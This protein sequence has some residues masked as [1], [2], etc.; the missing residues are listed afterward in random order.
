MTSPSNE[1]WR[2]TERCTA[3]P[4]SRPYPDTFHRC[5]E[6][7][8]F[9]EYWVVRQGSKEMSFE[10]HSRVEDACCRGQ[11]PRAHAI[12]PHRTGFHTADLPALQAFRG[13]TLQRLFGVSLADATG[14]TSRLRFACHAVISCADRRIATVA[15]IAMRNGFLTSRPLFRRVSSPIRGKAIADVQRNIIPPL[16]ASS[17]SLVTARPKTVRRL[18]WSVDVLGRRRPRRRAAGWLELS[19]AARCGPAW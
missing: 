2:P 4:S 18:P 5:P 14:R 3:Q 10:P 9:C 19:V 13:R 12:Q 11:Y 6:H 16:E 8:T 1:G 17:C 15:Q 7:A